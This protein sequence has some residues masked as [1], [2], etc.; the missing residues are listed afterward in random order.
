MAPSRAKKDTERRGG[1]AKGR[2][3]TAALLVVALIVGGVAGAVLER[4]VAN[5]P[6]PL[7]ETGQPGGE[8]SRYDVSDRGAH[9]GQRAPALTLTGSDGRTVE[10]DHRDG[11]PRVL[12]LVRDDCGP[13]D[14]AVVSLA[15][16]V[17]ASGYHPDRARYSL[18]VI[19]VGAGGSGASDWFARRGWEEPTLTFTADDDT[20]RAV[21]FTADQLPAWVFT[22]PDGT[23]A[24]R[25]Q[26]TLD[27]DTYRRITTLLAATIP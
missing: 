20:L 19:A 27:L 2:T 10:I 21:G 15:G 17:A 8:F 23:L 7:A 26:G 3:R 16:H 25:E 22:Y 14:A 1:A 12:L 18:A 4:Q 24:G 11:R 6:A 9:L 13:C 5:P